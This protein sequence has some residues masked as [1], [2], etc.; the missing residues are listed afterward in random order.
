MIYRQQQTCTCTR[1][2]HCCADARPPHTEAVLGYKLCS[3]SLVSPPSIGLLVVRCSQAVPM[4]PGIWRGS[5][6]CIWC[7]RR[8]LVHGDGGAP[9]TAY[10]VQRDKGCELRHKGSVW[11]SGRW[12]NM[13]TVHPACRVL[14][15]SPTIG[16]IYIWDS[17]RPMHNIL[18][19]ELAGTIICK[20]H[21]WI[22]IVGGQRALVKRIGAFLAAW[23]FKAIAASWVWWGF[24]KSTICTVARN[25]IIALAFHKMHR[26]Y[27]I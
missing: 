10:T 17:P 5:R 21:I 15:L 26:K 27:H 23:Q 18:G 24:G 22:S 19:S 6:I 3:L 14:I 16:N 8:Y 9:N 13:R 1:P 12:A 4:Q 25:I 7:T 20:L 11:S 2:P